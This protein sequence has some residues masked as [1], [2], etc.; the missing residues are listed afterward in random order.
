MKGPK[1]KRPLGFFLT[2]NNEIDA[3]TGLDRPH[4]MPVFTRM[5]NRYPGLMDPLKHLT[6]IGGRIHM[7]GAADSFED[8]FGALKILA[9]TKIQSHLGIIDV[10][11]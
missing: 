3:P 7:N 1:P 4:S 6:L 5:Q 11:I 2:P 9:Q 10:K 8:Q